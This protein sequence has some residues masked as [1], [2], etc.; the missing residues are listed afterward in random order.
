MWI[1]YL[2]VLTGIPS[3]STEDTEED[4]ENVIRL[5]KMFKL[6][7]LETIC[8]NITQE[9]EFLNPSIGTFLNDETGKKLKEMFLNQDKLC[10]IVFDVEGNITCS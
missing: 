5:S 1:L 3:L 7:Q 2:F 10:D 4:I 9:N 8:N 6:P